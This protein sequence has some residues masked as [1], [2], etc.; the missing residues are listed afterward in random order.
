MKKVLTIISIV[1]LL[2][3]SGL[4]TFAASGSFTASPGAKQAPELVDS[5]NVAEEKCEAE[6]NV[7]AYADRD[8]LDAQERTKMEAAYQAIASTNDL[9]TLGY[10]VKALANS[11]NYSS[12][13]FFVSDL[14]AVSYADCDAH[15]SHEFVVTIE[16][17]STKNYVGILRYANGV[18]MLLDDAVCEDGEIT[19]Y[20]DAPSPFAIVVHDGGMH[21]GAQTGSFADGEMK[22][23][24]I[25]LVCVSLIGIGIVVNKLRNS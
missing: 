17:A 2:L 14:F 25:C 11:L 1:L 22:I 9:G 10:D 20:M 16:P 3:C 15:M 4:S 13:Q 19:F 24:A 7:V 23:L 21:A 8:T 6:V 5:E 12:D 18:W